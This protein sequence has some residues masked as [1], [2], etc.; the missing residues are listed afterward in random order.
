MATLNGRKSQFSSTVSEQAA[1]IRMQIQVSRDTQRR[2][3]IDESGASPWPESVLSGTI[4]GDNKEP[5]RYDILLSWL[6]SLS[7]G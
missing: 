4:S 3:D 7:Y 5:V 1:T 6:F 2:V